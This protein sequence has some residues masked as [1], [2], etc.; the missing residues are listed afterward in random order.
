MLLAQ[1]W[2]AEGDPQNQVYQSPNGGKLLNLNQQPA[3]L[4]CGVAIFLVVFWNIKKKV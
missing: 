2:L 3:A 4:D 1:S